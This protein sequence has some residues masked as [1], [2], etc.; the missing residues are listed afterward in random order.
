MLSPKARKAVAIASVVLASLLLS[1]FTLIYLL[2]L[3]PSAR[4]SRLE[5]AADNHYYIA[6]EYLSPIATI[7][8]IEDR[9][10]SL[11]KATQREASEAQSAEVEAK[12][13]GDDYELLLKA[14]TLNEPDRDR[15]SKKIEAAK[16]VL[17]GAKDF[18]NWLKEAERGANT[19]KYT[20]EAFKEQ[21]KGLD[22]LNQAITQVNNG[23]TGP[24]LQAG[25][26]IT[27]VLDNAKKAIV[28]VQNY[29]RNQD[30]GQLKLMVDQ[31]IQANIILKKMARI[32]KNDTDS[33]NK[34]VDKLNESI[35][36]A[37]AIATASPIAKDL[38]GWLE[39]N[40]Y[41]DG[42]RLIFHFKRAGE[43]WPK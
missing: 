23:Q 12:E 24:A 29:E 27:A 42:G 6:K 1:S 31:Y 22:M 28:K 3:S 30:I 15:I 39:R 5:K 35:K 19:I 33:Y 8:Q 26:K 4:A 7:A 38:N 41:Y 43:I 21:A 32:P 34:E 20:N 36:K 10:T 2:F 13:A 37:S 40:F 25:E 17:A 11:T 14:A 9:T 16:N 18:K